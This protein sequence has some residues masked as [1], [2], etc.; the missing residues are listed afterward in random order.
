[1]SAEEASELQNEKSFLLQRLTKTWADE[2]A[3]RAYRRVLE[4]VAAW[5]DQEPIRMTLSLEAHDIRKHVMSHAHA[6]AELPTTLG[7]L[8]NHLNKWEGLFARIL[9]TMH[10]AEFASYGAKMADEILGVTA[11]RVKT[12][13][14]DY[15]L[16]NVIRFYGEFYGRDKHVEHA[17]WIAGYILAHRCCLLNSRDAYRARNEFREPQVLD[18]AMDYLEMAGWVASMSKGHAKRT[19]LWWV[20]PRVHQLFAERAVAE[21][22]RRKDEVQKI[23]KAAAALKRA[24]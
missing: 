12:L 18:R 17:S 8:K 22:T 13:M 20:D 21:R 11:E 23:Q 2:D 4:T 19:T 10:A 15:L 5:R 7:P 6:L 24:A 14:L 3:D 1:M 16:P 9:L